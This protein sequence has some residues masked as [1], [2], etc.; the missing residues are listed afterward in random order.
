MSMTTLILTLLA[1]NLPLTPEGVE[2]RKVFLFSLSDRAKAS[3]FKAIERLAASGA[4][5]TECEKTDVDYLRTCFKKLLIKLI[6]PSNALR[7]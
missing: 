5:L 1:I 2:S 3:R 6:D 4:E 7:V